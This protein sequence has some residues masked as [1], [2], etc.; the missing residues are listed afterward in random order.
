MY[1][2]SPSACSIFF[3]IS[4]WTR[5][6]LTFVPKLK[7]ITPSVALSR[8]FRRS[9]ERK[10]LSKLIHWNEFYLGN[11]DIRIFG[12]SETPMKS[13]QEKQYITFWLNKLAMKLVWLFLLDMTACNTP[14]EI[15]KIERK[16]FREI[17][18][19]F[20]KWPFFHQNLYSILGKFH[21]S[22]R[23][24]K[25]IF[26]KWMKKGENECIFNKWTNPLWTIF[27]RKVWVIEPK[28]RNLRS[29]QVPSCINKISILRKRLFYWFLFD[30]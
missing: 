1:G 30:Q 27:L 28:R 13:V 9:F 14:N 12:K 21:I 26:W 23:I 10:C 7:Y 25:N 19:N 15:W 18:K 16:P 29:L 11:F 22:W 24:S 8:I 20:Y 17:R 5:S 4:S 3:F 6:N 2:K